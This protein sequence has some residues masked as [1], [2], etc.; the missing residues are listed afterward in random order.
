MARS[1]G[2]MSQAR[3]GR[4][5]ALRGTALCGMVVYHT[6]W[7]LSALGWPTTNPAASPGWTL[8]GHGV[9]ATFL[10]LSGL[11][12]VLAQPSGL[13]AALR[14]LFVLMLAAAGV[15]A[16]SFWF[17]P[18]EPILFGILHCLLVSNAVAL[19]V[20]RW[21]AAARLGL[22]AVTIAAPELWRS[23]R[24]D[25]WPFAALGLGLM[26][27]QTLDYR[28][29]LPWMAAV[30]AGT[31]LGNLV[32]R[33]PSL[34]GGD[35]T[36]PRLLRWLGRHSL[37][38]YLLHQPVLYGALILA[39][40][41]LGGAPPAED[42]FMRQC[43]S[44]CSATGVSPGLCRAACACTAERLAAEAGSPGDDRTRLT[45]SHLEAV[46]RVCRAAGG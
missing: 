38:F 27:P 21:P 35:R 26:P 23:A 18:D 30:L 33:R 6:A 10:I 14:R 16:A 5:D 24:F 8:F 44:D 20:L 42:A 31:V 37:S 46:G 36:G 12:L 2:A 22:A 29:V 41:V 4:L 25:D 34:G 39:G 45:Q 28:P 40:L 3:L 43:R 19:T 13:R 9:A 15:T 11:S 17:A 1:G 7:D 32:Q